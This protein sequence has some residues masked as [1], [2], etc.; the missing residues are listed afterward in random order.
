MENDKTQNPALSK[1]AVSGSAFLIG[2]AQK[3]FW[4]WYLLPETL[5]SHKLSGMF[6]FS[7]SNV[8]KVNF[9]AMPDI[10]QE[11]IIN[12]WFESIGFHIGRDMINNYWLENSTFFERLGQ[13]AY[14]YISIFK[15]NYDVIKKSN[16]IYNTHFLTNTQ[17]DR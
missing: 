8:I 5:K 12:E 10:C 4:D 15:S 3:D 9:L 7:N 13:N 17:A 6:K 1:T 2:K 11:A 14:D 16:E